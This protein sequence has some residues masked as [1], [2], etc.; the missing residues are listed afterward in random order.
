M[1]TYYFIVLKTIKCED[2]DRV[3]I[4]KGTCFSSNL[5]E[6]RIPN[7][8]ELQILLASL[9]LEKNGIVVSK[10]EFLR[11]IKNKKLFLYKESEL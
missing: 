5:K 2:K 6:V 9:P 10:K 3:P 8:K 4:Y 7:F 11:L 1:K